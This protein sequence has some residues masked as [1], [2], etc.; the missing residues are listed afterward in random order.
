[1]HGNCTIGMVQME[2]IVGDTEGNLAKITGIAKQAALAGAQ[3]VCYPELALHGYGPQEAADLAEPL[4]GESVQI[5]SQCAVD[6]G[7][8]L[9]VGMA[10]AGSDDGKPYLT[11]LVAFPDSRLGV[12]RKTHLGRS[13]KKYFSPG[14]TFPVFWAH[15]VCFGVGICWDWHFPEVAT[16]YSLKGAEILFAPHASPKAVGDR[17]ELWLRYLGARAYDNSVYLGACNVLGSNG[18]GQ[19]FKG[20]ALVLGPKGEM[21]AESFDG[22]GGML[23]A[24][25]PAEVLNTLR[26]QSGRSMKERFFLAQRRKELYRE[27]IELDLPEKGI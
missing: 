17:K 8:T 25:L 9:L 3:I 16:I 12:Y 19:E 1:M 11:Q 7:V 26:S 24:E 10:E 22:R 20:G 18:K 14:D 21:L 15:G 27:I 13:E 4:A 5:I 23:L 6:L 2:S